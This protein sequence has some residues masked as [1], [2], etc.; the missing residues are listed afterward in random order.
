MCVHHGCGTRFEHTY[1][2]V[3]ELVAVVGVESLCISFVKKYTAPSRLDLKLGL[4]Y[5]WISWMSLSLVWLFI[6]FINLYISCSAFK[7]RVLLKYEYMEAATESLY[8]L[9]CFN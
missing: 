5:L 7:I 2:S 3:L 6:H 9:Q 4:L 8:L 1:W